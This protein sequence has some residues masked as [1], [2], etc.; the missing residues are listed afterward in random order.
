M[1]SLCPDQ[2]N[3][4]KPPEPVLKPSQLFK[5]PDPFLTSS[6]PQTP[7]P[8]QQGLR[9]G[10]PNPPPMLSFFP[11]LLPP[12]TTNVPFVATMESGFKRL[13]AFDQNKLAQI[14]L[15]YIT[16]QDASD[17]VFVTNSDEVYAFGSNKNGRLGVGHQ[18][19]VEEPTLIK[20]LCG[21]GVIKISSGCN[22]M[23][24]LTSS[25]EVWTW[26]V[27]T[28]VFGAR[29]GIPGL[30]WSKA[31]CNPIRDIECTNYCIN[32]LSQSGQLVWF[33]NY[34]HDFVRKHMSTLKD[35]LIISMAC[36]CDHTL[37]LSSC[38]KI[39]AWGRN[40][41]GQLGIG[42][43]N[44]V[45]SSSP[46]VIALNVT[47]KQIACGTNH[48]LLLS[49]NGNIYS[50]GSN[51]YGQLGIGNSSAEVKPQ[52]IKKAIEFIEICAIGNTS[53]ALSKTGTIYIWGS[54]G[55]KTY[56]RPKYTTDTS[57]QM[58][59]NRSETVI[60]TP[61]SI[62]YGQLTE[63]KR[64]EGLSQV[65]ARAFNNPQYS[66]L[67]FTFKKKGTEDQSECIFGHKWFLSENSQYFKKLLAENNASE[68]EIVGNSYEAYYHL[69]R[70][71]YTEEIETQDIEVLKEMLSISDTLLDEAKK[72][73]LP[74][75]I[76]P[77]ITKDNVCSIF[78]CAREFAYEE[79]EEYCFEFMSEN[80]KAYSEDRR[81]RTFGRESLEIFFHQLFQI[82]CQLI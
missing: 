82:L 35:H 72:K 81:L 5:P 15:V 31:N 73:N 13:S 75:S 50:F 3:F 4:F 40:T 78:A 43:R 39:L 37:A 6:D 57:F 58:T 27:V 65:M 12:F 53:M 1:N 80:I 45:D 47:I 61:K 10:C 23:A 36:G 21:K 19:V 76:K 77:L 62:P 66:D 24:A 67:K 51:N 63:K 17:V 33:G 20:E 74:E 79:L 26:G 18:L 52:V 48:S 46:Q 25:G 71:L 9:F 14:K 38:A 56:D 55:N 59:I 68:Y 28:W 70:Y 32:L 2:A 34:Q 22:F 60:F 64:T 69:I 8:A 49:N 44:C 29:Q 42:T 41:E 54:V 30:I 7:V 16:P 11:A